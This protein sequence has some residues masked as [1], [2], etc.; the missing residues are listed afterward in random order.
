MT[1]DEFPRKFGPY[2][3]LKPL[4][5]GGMGALY[6]ALTGE[7]S[8]QKLCVI[9]TAL[10]HLADKGYL[11]R[12][13][14][15]AKVVVRLSHGNL[16]SVFDAG[17]IQGELFLA[18]DF[19]EGK[20]L[21]AVWNRCAQKG[22]A[23]PVDVA[24]HITKELVRGLGYAHSFSGL[25]LVHRDVSPPN[26]L[27]SY[28]GEVKLTDFGLAS[29]TL[30]LEKT[31]PG[32]IYGKVSYMAP[33]QARGE[34]LDGRTDLYAAGVML[35]ELLTGRQLFPATTGIAGLGG[36]DDLLDRV[37]SPKVPAP[38]SKT[39]RVPP[40]LDAIVIKALA[41]DPADRYQTGE[42]FRTALAAFLAKTSPA[43]DG[44]HVAA[45]LRRLFVDDIAKEKASRELLMGMGGS[46]LPKMGTPVAPQPP[47]PPG[48][49]DPFEAKTPVYNR[50]KG[51]TEHMDPSRPP[52]E[53]TPTPLPSNVDPGGPGRT[54]ETR[55][56]DGPRP[57]VPVEATSQIVG[58]LLGGR[59]RIIRLCG[60]GGMGR[61]YEAEH[62]EIGKHVA[63]KV[64]HPA[65]TRTPDVVERFR[66]EARAAS[67]I[68]HPNIVNV[69][70]SGTTED[71]AFFFVME[72]IEG[73]ELGLAIHREG[74]LPVKRALRIADQICQ[75]LQAA[76]DAQVVHRDLKPENVLLIS[77]EGRPDFVKVLDFGIAR[78]SE[79][80]ESPTKTPGR[81]LT[82]PGVAMG[83]PEYMAPEQAAGKSA[84]ARSDIYALGSIMYEML[85]GNPP[86][87]G[88]NVM[89]VLHRKATETPP[90]VRS[91]R[92]DVPVTVDA[93]VE[94]AMARNPDDRPQTMAAFAAEIGL[95]LEAFVGRRTPTE[96]QQ[97][98]KETGFFVGSIEPVTGL[99]SLGLSRK[100]TA[101][102]AGTL[103]V[104]G[105]LVVA[106]VAFTSSKT[107]SQKPNPATA[108]VA[109]VQVVPPPPKVV[110]AP[111]EAAATPAAS[112]PN[113]VPGEEWNMAA[114][115]EPSV[116]PQPEPPGPVVPGPRPKRKPS[117]AAAGRDFLGEGQRL[118]NAQKY[119]DA[120]AAFEKAMR[121]KPL[122]GRALLGMGQVAFQ[123][124]DYAEAVRRAKQGASSG[125]GVS[126]HVLLGDAYFKLKDFPSAKK[127]YSDA[128]KLDPNNKAARSNLE[129]TE[130]RLQ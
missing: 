9:K 33:E 86:Y 127:A 81:R 122:K 62:I 52:S 78:V 68:G 88:E 57:D 102:A 98:R 115:N 54:G 51:S 42:E 114:Q 105:L 77:K 80:E 34:P 30:K 8:M 91:L 18:M 107:S 59:Y 20:D 50:K 124:Q 126:A 73:V 65:Y 71:G 104:I 53:V 37:R 56:I 96:V 83:T 40:E 4:A 74:P 14:D 118:L 24:V 23:F 32:V 61:V 44:E 125:A 87:E 60:E 90:P 100:S 15:E 89:E 25:N 43:T 116:A 31:A 123:K 113:P 103:G 128:L 21:R 110:P 75:A 3:L 99:A 76:H 39:G 41:S 101:I 12:F 119:D 29:S 85:T 64:L 17:Q 97:M 7:R 117:D 28:S 130:R 63:V 45:F 58:A 55:A 35:W 112:D 49:N 82:R 79:V 5:R 16:V 93:L 108:H 106:K 129:S 13:R 48:M 84:D 46:L 67:R 2:V 120:K 92:P 1:A 95:V 121:S 69:T 19:I 36:E 11:Q 22:I 109:A 94:R 111:P 10:H 38:S 66:R 47:D 72:F 26:L 6:L 70:D 27:L